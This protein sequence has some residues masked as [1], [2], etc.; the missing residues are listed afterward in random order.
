LKQI[1]HHHRTHPTPLPISMLSTSTNS[2]LSFRLVPHTLLLFPP[3]LPLPPPIRH[4]FLRIFHPVP[5]LSHARALSL[6]L[7]LSCRLSFLS[8]SR[9]LTLSRAL[10]LALSRSASTHTPSLTPHPNLSLSLPFKSPHST[11]QIPATYS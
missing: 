6:V 9:T 1:I 11:L 4:V 10:S 7:S 8:L 5:Q 2:R 3:R